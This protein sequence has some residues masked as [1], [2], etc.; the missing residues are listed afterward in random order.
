MLSL[1]YGRFRPVRAQLARKL[2]FNRIASIPRRFASM[3]A[4]CPEGPDIPCRAEYTRRGETRCLPRR[5]YAASAGLYA[6]LSRCKHSPTITCY[7]RQYLSE[8]R[9]LGSTLLFVRVDVVLQCNSHQ[10]GKTSTLPL[11][12]RFQGL[13]QL[14]RDAD[15]YALHGLGLFTLHAIVLLCAC[16]GSV[17]LLPLFAV[18]S[19][20]S[21]R[22]S[23]G[24]V[25]LACLGR[26]CA[27]CLSRSV[28]CVF[29]VDAFMI[30]CRTAPVKPLEKDFFDIAGCQEIVK[31]SQHA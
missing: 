5:V 14:R 10:I 3:C 12:L 7:V 31:A 2:Q 18:R 8:K 29:P 27:P 20:A 9:A 4:F 19:L 15:C 24:R 28:V 30:A 26:S 21:A 16:Q 22:P 1:L 25:C 17:D 6:G 23:V 13:P 11:C